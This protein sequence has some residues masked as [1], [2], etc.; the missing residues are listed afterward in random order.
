MSEM[1]TTTVKLEDV[2]DSMK[3][4]MGFFLRS[5]K[6]VILF[7]VLGIGLSLAYFAIQKPSY[8]ATVTFILEEKS[9]GMSGGLSGLASQF[10]FDIGSLSGSPGMFAGDNILDI[11]KSRAII[12]KVLLSKADSAQGA[13]SATLADLFLDFS[14]LKTKWK[15]EP[16]ALANLSFSKLGANQPHSLL[17]DSVLTMIYEKIYK[18]NLDADR[19][20]KKGSIIKVSTLSANQ[21]FSKMFTE[22]VLYET[23]DLYVNVKT[24][25]SAANVAKLQ[26]RADSLLRVLNGKSYE[27]ANSQLVDA[28]SAFKSAAVPAEVTQR[29]KMV[30]YAI[31]T[32][33]MKNLEAS[34][35]GL[36]SQT[37]AIQ[38]LD[39]SRFPLE[40]KRKSL[41]LLLAIGLLAGL[42]LSFL[43]VFIAYPSAGKK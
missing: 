10:G 37:P 15:N 18:K 2:F 27:N 29:D 41:G 34:R 16:P 23:R 14:R 21:V 17:Q 13:G 11:L 31:Y 32:E 35:M 36:A 7:V 40:D 12:E 38:L 33:V 25:V 42:G 6:L 26:Q 4:F 5:I 39:Y 30:T 3:R 1:Q 20:N 22:R 9:S 28:N 19:L 43:F 8:E 24:S